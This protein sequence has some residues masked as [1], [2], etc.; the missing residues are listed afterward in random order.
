MQREREIKYFYFS[1]YE[2][3]SWFLNNSGVSGK[4]RH[5]AHLD[6]QPMELTSYERFVSFYAYKTCKGPVVK[7]LWNNLSIGERK[8]RYVTLS[9]FLVFEFR[10]L[11]IQ[12]IFLRILFQYTLLQ[13]DIQ[14]LRTK[15]SWITC[16]LCLT[17]WA[18]ESHTSG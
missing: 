8:G 1:E 12:K 11:E 17:F 9:R 7:S 2:K 13:L 5:S 15:L 6:S 18:Q 14:R 10:D 3:Y 16:Y 4:S